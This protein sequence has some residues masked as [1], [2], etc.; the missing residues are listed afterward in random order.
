MQ[1][2]GGKT[3][4]G[5]GTNSGSGSSGSTSVSVSAHEIGEIIQV[6]ANFVSDAYVDVGTLVDKATYP[7]LYN[8]LLDGSYGTQ[9]T[10][11]ADLPAIT[12]S[13]SSQATTPLSYV[14]HGSKVVMMLRGGLCVSSSDGI[15]FDYVGALP[16]DNIVSNSLIYTSVNLFYSNGSRIVFGTKAFGVAYLYYSDDGGATWARFSASSVESLL[17]AASASPY[18]KTRDVLFDGTN[19]LLFNLS[20][21]TVLRSP[22]LLTWTS[23]A[24]TSANI[25]ASSYLVWAINPVT[26]GIT[27]I[28]NQKTFYSSDSGST[29]TET[30][31][32][33]TGSSLTNIVVNPADG[34]L[35]FSNWYSSGSTYYQLVWSSADGKTFTQAASLSSSAANLG[36]M[37]LHGSQMVLCSPSFTVNG[38]AYYCAQATPTSWT[39]VTTPAISNN[40]NTPFFNSISFRLCSNIIT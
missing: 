4:S 23:T 30:A 33:L 31:L 21:K 26:K 36:T 7:D 15:N 5:S 37:L 1:T 22:D 27:I 17:I 2:I 32:A 11:G 6:P 16:A 38:K 28:N 9:W 35:Y 19:Y 29:W 3:S 12:P 25:L 39:V 40:A 24:F 10:A 20:T 8:R 13:E 34:K 14:L 18:P